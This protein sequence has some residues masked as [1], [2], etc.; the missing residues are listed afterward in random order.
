MTAATRS[1]AADT[2]LLAA[3]NRRSAICARAG[4]GRGWRRPE[5]A[6]FPDKKNSRVAATLAISPSI[7]VCPRV[8]LRSVTATHLTKQIPARSSAFQSSCLFA[9]ICEFMVHRGME[10]SAS[11]LSTSAEV[12]EGLAAAPPA[13]PVAEPAAVSLSPPPAPADGAGATPASAPAT[14]DPAL[15]ALCAPLSEADPCGPDLDAAGDMAYLNFFASIVLPSSFFAATDGKPFFSTQNES[16]AFAKDALPGQIE[17]IEPLLKRTRDLRLLIMR[18]QLL[19][20]S[21]NVGGFAVTMA[22]VAEWL[23]KF[24]DSLHP[25]PHGDDVEARVHA[26]AALDFP[27]VTFSLQYA[28]LFEGRRIGAV[29]Y[30]TWMIASGEINARAGEQKH[31]TTAIIDAMAELDPAVIATARKHF[32]VLKSALGRIRSAFLVRSAS[33]E[34][35]KLPALVEAISALIDPV[36]AEPEKQAGAPAA[37]LT[38]SDAAPTSLAQAREALAAIAEYYSHREPSS[39]ILPLVRQAH[40]L[41]GKSFVEV[42]NILIPTQME[43]ASFQIGADQIFELPVGRLAKLAETAPNWPADRGGGPANEALAGEDPRAYSIQSRSQAIAL[44]EQVQRF[45][46]AAEPSSP[47]PM[48]CERART[49]AERDFMGVLRDVLPKAALKSAGSDK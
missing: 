35:E 44:L 42:M 38:P 11:D 43:K 41:I 34:L 2:S 39:P 7:A 31:P 4:S 47:I 20:L 45:F 28:P 37:A 10:V 8:A 46:R 40:Q 15:A 16:L 13:V 21:R 23:D 19:I 3:P 12:A 17:A 22:A 27:I 9:I 24:W 25:R 29:S 18:A 6:P 49:L 1:F 33:Y 48:L 32:A 36:V 14:R 5:N 26:L 30:R